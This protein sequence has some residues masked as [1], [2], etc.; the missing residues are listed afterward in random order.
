[1]KH[2]Q[3][4]FQDNPDMLAPQFEQEL[5]ADLQQ[6]YEHQPGA[7]LYEASRNIVVTMYGMTGTVAELS[8]RCPVP[9]SERSPAA[10]EV[11]TARA[12]E[13]SNIAISDQ[14]AYLRSDAKKN[15]VQ[16]QPKPAVQH[17][18]KQKVETVTEETVQ[19]EPVQ[20]VT[21]RLRDVEQ[22]IGVSE[23]VAS[24]QETTFSREGTSLEAGMIEL[25]AD[26]TA[27]S[28]PQA[29]LPTIE[30]QQFQV[31]IPEHL[32][33]R[34]SA[35]DQYQTEL[36]P[37]DLSQR[38]LEPVELQ[39]EAEYAH[40]E[41]TPEPAYELA[42]LT[43]VEMVTEPPMLQEAPE[44][45]EQL[46]KL[47][48]E[49]EVVASTLGTET[50]FI[51]HTEDEEGGEKE[52]AVEA[53]V[54]L[55]VTEATPDETTPDYQLLNT[56]SQPKP[57]IL[58]MLSIAPEA[59]TIAVSSVEKAAA[60]VAMPA[61]AEPLL[62]VAFDTLEAPEAEALAEVV[63]TMTLIAERLQVL[64]GTDRGEGEEARQIEQVLTEYYDQVCATIKLPVTGE[65]RL[66]FIATIRSNSFQT[67]LEETFELP[68]D[69]GTHEYKRDFQD[70]V[71]QLPVMLQRTIKLA[72]MMV[73]LGTS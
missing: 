56:L 55:V 35:A 31:D 30:H 54:G 19:R 49:S 52:Q 10:M 11:F 64:V 50:H 62:R 69:E 18:Q 9:L 47:Y 26:L 72:R 4:P 40:A 15:A 23:S 20:P 66:Q 65:E 48:Y 38:S 63:E 1:M 39:L 2:E 70:S 51:F 33:E 45:V 7:S 32:V 24:S 67:V 27:F 3:P 37:L 6:G 53:S 73:S 60:I 8:A 12:L 25:S 44:L 46:A 34:V 13:D 71:Y 14:F 5:H 17:K 29:E 57:A 41:S 59:E 58:N 36:K 61:A 21:T 42:S 22:T 43:P 28:L 16:E 68:I